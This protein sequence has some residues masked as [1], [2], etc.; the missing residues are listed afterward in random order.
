MHSAARHRR[1]HRA[2]DRPEETVNVGPGEFVNRPGR[3]DLRLP[4]DLIGQQVADPGNRVL[5]EQ[6]C[7]HRCC[8][9]GECGPELRAG[10]LAGIGAERVDGRIE[11]DSAEPAW[12]DQQQRS[13]R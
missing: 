7:F 3:V 12:I 9:A 10:D 5:I 13:R 11:A 2:P 6:A 8:P 1:L 4:E